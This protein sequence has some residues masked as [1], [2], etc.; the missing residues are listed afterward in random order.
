[1]SLSSHHNCHHLSAGP[2]YFVVGVGRLFIDHLLCARHCSEDIMRNK[3][4]DVFSVEPK[5]FQKKEK[6]KKRSS[7]KTY[8]LKNVSYS[9][10]S[11]E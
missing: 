11:K 8:T 1:M 2:F 4:T 6:K 5:F 7:L 3:E 9:E 10:N